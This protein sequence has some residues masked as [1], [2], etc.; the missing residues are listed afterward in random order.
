MGVQASGTSHL[1][2]TESI[3]QILEQSLLVFPVWSAK[4]E[5]TQCLPLSGGINPQIGDT[6]KPEWHGNIKVHTLNPKHQTRDLSR[7]CL[8]LDIRARNLSFSDTLPTLSSVLS[9]NNDCVWARRR[10]LKLTEQSQ[11]GH[12][13]DISERQ[14]RESWR[15]A[16]AFGWLT[17]AT[18]WEG[19]EDHEVDLQPAWH[20][21]PWR[22]PHQQKQQIVIGMSDDTAVGAT[23][24]LCAL[25]KTINPLWL[26][27]YLLYTWC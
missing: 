14:L 21:S 26:E 15:C 20:W 25:E 3:L 24:L 1:L 16:L 23:L 13:F 6:A 19:C 22:F 5:E 18:N 17:K 10:A 7:I 8:F 9:L 27:Y 12:M 4:D 11:E 2:L